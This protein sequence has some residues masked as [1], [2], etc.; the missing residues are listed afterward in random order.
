MNLKNLV[1]KLK[2]QR[3]AELEA[4]IR[5]GK[6][7]TSLLDDGENNVGNSTQLQPQVLPAG[8]NYTTEP[9]TTANNGRVLN[10]TSSS[11]KGQSITV[12]LLAARVSGADGNVG[13]LTG[14]IEFG[15]GAVAT[16]IEFD[17]PVGPF[18]GQAGFDK[19]GDTP[20]D[21]GAVVQVPTGIVRA[22]F[23][24]DN[25]F[26]TPTVQGWAFG[27]TGSPAI[28]NPLALPFAPNL[29]GAGPVAIKSFSVYFGRHFS[30]LYKTQYVFITAGTAIL[31][32]LSYAALLPTIVGPVYCVPP[33]A[34]SVRVV[35]FP[36][37][38]A[39][40]LTLYDGMPSAPVAGLDFGEAYAIASGPAPAIALDGNTAFVAV[41]SASTGNAD[42]VSAVKLVYE[43]GF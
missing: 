21:G 40:T 31:T 20:R 17:V 16:S 4:A 27:G 18:I 25:A 43:I 9:Q 13:P 38:A 11:A 24:Y 26:L 30:R 6:T 32:T 19:A 1:D 41:A 42:K 2:M 23:R 36:Q 14:I 15:N 35:R 7:G 28:A 10:L 5:A 34:K 22:F 8:Q 12:V 3:Q 33:H 37:T 29:Q 39:L